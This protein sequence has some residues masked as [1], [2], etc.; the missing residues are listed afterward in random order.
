MNPDG[1]LEE[2]LEPE[3]PYHRNPDMARSTLKGLASMSDLHPHG[4]TTITNSIIENLA[5][6]LNMHHQNATSILQ[7]IPIMSII[8]VTV[9]V[10]R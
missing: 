3:I 7:L 8:I 6:G 4:L 2:V 9:L 5:L 1:R 10:L